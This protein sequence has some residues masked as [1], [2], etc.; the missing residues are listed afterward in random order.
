[1][2]HFLNQRPKTNTK[3]KVLKEFSKNCSETSKTLL[4]Y[5]ELI[6]KV[7]FLL[8]TFVLVDNFFSVTSLIKL[9]DKNR[10]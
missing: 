6:Q 7:T 8:T 3:H 4:S 9:T 2:S 10:Y 1:M 5:R